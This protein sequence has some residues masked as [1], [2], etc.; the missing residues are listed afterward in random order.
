MNN[1][2][3][4]LL[5][6]LV[7]S[8]I[9]S[10]KVKLASV[11]TENMVIQQNK[12][13][14]FYGT[15]DPGEHIEIRFLNK[16]KKVRA[17]ISGNW[18][19]AFPSQ[20]FGGPYS[21]KVK[22]KLNDIQ[23]DNILIGDVWL[24]SGQS[25]M[26]WIVKNVKDAPIEISRANHPK[27]RSFNVHQAI[28]MEP[29]QNVE[30]EWSICTPQT[31]EN[32][33]AVAYFFAR[34]LNKTLDVPIGIINSSWGG[35]DIEAWI[36]PDAFTTLTSNYSDKYSGEKIDNIEE[37]L[38]KNK[39]RKAMFYSAISTERGMNEKWYL[40]E[41]KT[42][43]W[44]KM[45][46][47]QQWE[48]VLG[49][50]DGVIW[51][52]YDFELTKEDANKTAVI[53]L[54]PIDDDD[55][56]WVNGQEIGS[57]SGYTEN[58]IYSIPE[59]VLKEGMNSIVV[60]IT[61]FYG[62][63]GFYGNAE[64]LYVEV[65]NNRYNLSGTWLYK[66]AVTNKE[67]DFKEPS[68]NMQPSLLYNAMINPFINYPIKGVI[69]YQGE[70]NVPQ[71]FN[72]RTLFP[73]MIKDWRNKWNEEF[74]FYWVQLANYLE[75]DS[76]PKESQWAELRWAQ[77]ETL[78]LPNTGQVV[79][80]DIGEANDIHPRNK[81]EVG[82][83]LAFVALKNTYAVKEIVASGPT[84]KNHH[85]NGNQL[86]IDFENIGNGLI[87]PN[88]YGYIEGFTIA[89]VDE[90]FYWAKAFIDG[91]KVIVYSPLVD[92]PVAVRYSWAN[93]P[94]VNLFNSEG[95]PAAPFKTDEW[96]WSTEYSK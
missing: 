30:G 66:E 12:P 90:K 86:I 92:E 17:D 77:T 57:T 74:P 18:S 48:N 45:D 22:G 63:G 39:E 78:S 24:C 40:P 65:D 1:T 76:S 42:L 87:T 21:L 33:S 52:R 23:Y 46:I 6:F 93:N 61:D 91:N 49:D 95:L 31:V 9:S 67:Y 41:T 82:K 56:T 5:L 81:Q 36:S 85:M 29:K 15:A 68:P 34:E 73:L 38:E 28:G 80:T 71:A 11:F 79:I 50:V 96:K 43:S 14:K 16:T 26:E 47:P 7:I 60:K 72:Y 13:I 32:F 70:N 84:Y 75:K 88:K 69:W 4:I 55:I 89:G 3:K 2:F 10:A 54:G 83:R 94:D 64:N 53:Q 8:S 25:N 44:K 58:R 35:T 20:S 37:F 59:N 62:G 27:I 19:V 51:Y